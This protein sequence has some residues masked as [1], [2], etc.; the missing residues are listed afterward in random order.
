MKNEKGLKNL[1]IQPWKCDSLLVC[2]WWRPY[3]SH[4]PTPMGEVKCIRGKDVRGLLG[5]GAIGEDEESLG[6][7][8]ENQR[9]RRCEEKKGG[10]GILL[11]EKEEL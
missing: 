2:Q 8:R 10:G 11:R 9:I 6:R 7:K 4:C 3:Q 5:L 1:Q